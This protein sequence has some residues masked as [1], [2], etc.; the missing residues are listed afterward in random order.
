MVVLLLFA[1]HPVT[2]RFHIGKYHMDTEFHVASKPKAIAM[3][4]STL[5]S[6]FPEDLLPVPKIKMNIIK[7]QRRS[8]AVS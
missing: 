5:P 7:R 1:L 4:K 2:R 6:P 8:G 3:L